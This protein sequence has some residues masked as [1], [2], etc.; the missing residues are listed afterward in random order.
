MKIRMKIDVGGTF[1]GIDAGVKP[2]DIVDIEGW[3]AERYIA[4]GYAEPYSKSAPP[5]EKAVLPQDDVE[6]A[7]LDV[8]PDDDG[9]QPLDEQEP[10]KKAPAK[11]RARST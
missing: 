9:P 4:N 3:I 1:H 11:T 6:T 5:V 7:S 10:A 8:P 2:G